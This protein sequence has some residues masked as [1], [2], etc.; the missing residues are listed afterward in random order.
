MS[1][2]LM[3]LDVLLRVDFLG[4]VIC[5]LGLE[6]CNLFLSADLLEAVV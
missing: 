6:E 2:I 4:V 1:K 5:T 3:V